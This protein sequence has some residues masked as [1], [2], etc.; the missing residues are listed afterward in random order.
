MGRAARAFVL[1]RFTLEQA[2]KAEVE[3]LGE[4]VK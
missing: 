3:L 2:V 1:E 4:L